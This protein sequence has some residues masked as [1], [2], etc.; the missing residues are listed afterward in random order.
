MTIHLGTRDVVA[1]AANKRWRSVTE[2][3]EIIAGTTV[4]SSYHEASNTPPS[5]AERRPV[6]APGNTGAHPYVSAER[7]AIRAHEPRH[8]QAAASAAPLIERTALRRA[9]GHLHRRNHKQ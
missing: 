9:N 4:L 5:A 3:T 1:A 2:S 8:T 7:H 6:A